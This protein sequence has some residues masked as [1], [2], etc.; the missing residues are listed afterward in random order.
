MYILGHTALGY[1]IARPF[2][3]ID[4]EKYGPELLLFIFVFANIV[5]S[6]HIGWI[7]MVSHNLIGTF[8]YAGI[9]LIFFYKSGV[10]KAK[11]M[12]ILLLATGSHIIADSYFAGYYFFIPFSF[13]GFS[14][15]GF[16]SFEALI[17]ESILGILFFIVLIITKDLVILKKFLYTELKR[18]V[19]ELNF[20]NMFLPEYYYSYLFIGFFVFV[21]SQVLIYLISRYNFLLEGIWYQWLFFVVFIMFLVIFCYLFINTNYLQKTPKEAIDS[22]YDKNQ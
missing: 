4:N 16:G 9:W 10:M 19:K 8:A 7:R 22:L 11:Y 14:V 5:D 21:I 12:P 2:F 3:K 17:T 6:I 13:K 20:K 1:L 15:F 18:F